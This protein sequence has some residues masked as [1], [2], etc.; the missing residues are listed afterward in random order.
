MSH[1]DK[2]WMLYRASDGY[3]PP[4]G[5]SIVHC[6]DDEH[7]IVECNGLTLGE[8]NYTDPTE[9]VAWIVSLA[10]DWPL[11]NHS[12]SKDI[13]HTNGASGSAWYPEIGGI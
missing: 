12:Q 2:N 5:H 6:Q 3:T 8:M 4:D 1:E 7:K 10:P 9:P 11:L 13:V